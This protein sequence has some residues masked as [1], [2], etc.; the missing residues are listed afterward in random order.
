MCNLQKIETFLIKKVSCDC[1]DDHV[2]EDFINFVIEKYSTL[3]RVK[4]L[5]KVYRDAKKIDKNKIIIK[6]RYI[7][8]AILHVANAIE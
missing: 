4:E 6:D 3:H 5:Y 8:I 1:H 2:I 7:G